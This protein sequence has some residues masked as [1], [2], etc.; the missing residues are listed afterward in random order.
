MKWHKKVG[1]FA[2][3]VVIGFLWAA[4]YS[5]NLPVIAAPILSRLP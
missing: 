3:L 2:A 1:M 5:L 4:V